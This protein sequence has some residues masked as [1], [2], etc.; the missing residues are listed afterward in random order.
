MKKLQVLINGEWEWV[1]CNSQGTIKTTQDRSKALP[2][3]PFWA[4]DD[5]AYFESK[6]ANHTFRLYGG[7][8]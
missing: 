8:K 7:S 2:T 5:L 3:K 4:Q 6:F 1:F